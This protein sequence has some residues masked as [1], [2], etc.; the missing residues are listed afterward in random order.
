MVSVSLPPQQVTNAT[1]RVNVNEGRLVDARITGN[2]YFSSNNVMR[3]LPSLQEALVWRDEVINGQV[4]Q[5]E[6]DLANRN[7]DRQ[8]Y[9]VINPGPEPGTSA[10]DLRIKDRLPLHSHVEVNNES[11]P[12]T[13]EWRVNTTANY[14]NLWQLEH[15]IGIFYG[16]TPEE[17]KSGG[18]VDDYFFNRP[19]IANYGAYY[20]IPFGE[21]ESVQERISGS[22]NFGYDEVTHQFRL[23]PP[24]GRPDLT[25]SASG[26]S[27]D[28]GVKFGPASVVTNTPLLSIVSQD[29][30]QNIKLNNSAGAS[31]NV[32]FGATDTRRFNFS[33]GVEWEQEKFTSYNTNNFIITTVITNS[34]GQQ[35]VVT[36]VPSPQPK[37]VNNLSYARFSLGLGFFE[38]DAHGSSSGDLDFSGNL[39]GSPESVIGSSYTPKA[40]PEFGRANLALTRDQ[41][42]F[43]DWSLLL[44]AN[45]QAATGATIANDVYTI[46]GVNSVRGYL[47]GDERGD[48]GWFGSVELRTPFIATR[49][50]TLSGFAPAWLRG[51]VFVDCAQRFVL[52]PFPVASYGQSR[53]LWSTGFG[54]SVNINHRVDMRIIVGVPMRDSVNTVAGQP[55]VH[56]SMGGQF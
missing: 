45:G 28:T 50:A 7:A 37:F 26:S 9:P 53:F 48:D 34:Q 49:V 6:V 51:S 41:K 8:I 3:A 17:F 33:T 1:I 13:P 38:N 44:R 35:T 22:A 4:L 31:L 19:L 47:E 25:F 43:G 12:G 30:G 20:R 46:G 21:V 16:F 5:R 2:C 39:G 29:S 36:R 18:K 42:V 56:F 54:L 10:I 15:S 11:T 52:E 24:G 32:P 23:P 55:R 14:N 40:K 27:T